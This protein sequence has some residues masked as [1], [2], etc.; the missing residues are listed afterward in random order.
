MSFLQ[1]LAEFFTPERVYP[2]AANFL[3]FCFILVFAYV[4]N[5]IAGRV[6][7]GLRMR[8]VTAMQEAAG[9]TTTELDKRACTII[10]IVGKVVTVAIWAVAVVMALREIGFDIGPLLAGAGVAGLAIGFGAQNL[11]RD[12]ISGLFMLLENQIRVNDIAIVN[13]TGGVVEEVN[14]RTTVLR[15]LDGVVHVFPNGNIQT[16]ANMTRKFSFYV[17]DVGVAYKEDTDRVTEVLVGL[18]EEM[19]QEE[20]YKDDI[21]EPLEVLGVDKFADSAVVIKTRLKTRPLHQ[22]RIG[23]EMNRR[24][25]KKFDE[26]GIEIPF[27]HRSVYFGEASAP[28]RVDSGPNRDLV[29]AVV[30]EV[31]AERDLGRAKAEAKQE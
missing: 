18:A 5:R 8:I 25:K 12:V 31:L 11:V 10:A 3:R 26:L 22:F 28:F 4:A 17:F 30:R 21:F 7:R 16:L 15:S 1:G 9:G 6:I 24:I 29:K 20:A 27:P 19:M 14:L 13:G 2:F 23:R